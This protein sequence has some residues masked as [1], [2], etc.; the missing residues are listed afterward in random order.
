MVEPVKWDKLAGLCMMLVL[1]A[2]VLYGLWSYRLI[3]TPQDAMTLFVDFIKPL[4][5]PQKKEEPPPPPPPKKV[6]LVKPREITAPPLPVLV[7]NAPVVSPVEPVAPPPPP[8]PLPEPVVEAP[9]GPP[10]PDPVVA[11]PPEPPAP[12]VLNGDLAVACPQR[13]APEYPAM[14]RRLGEQGRVVLRV[15]LDESG[16]VVAARVKETSGFRRLDDAG[17]AAVK[18]WHCNA[19]TRDGQAVKAVALQ[20]FN[21]VLEGRR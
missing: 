12:V 14:S 6:R 19:P 17:L 20:P 15:E 4:P 21:F 3:P 7:A 8:E 5:P 1:H 16:R 18:T 10:L 9:P 13:F 11:A 2:V